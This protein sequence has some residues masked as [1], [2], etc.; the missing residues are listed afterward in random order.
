MSKSSFIWAVKKETP[1]SIGARAKAHKRVFVSVSTSHIEQD[2][3]PSPSVSGCSSQS[4]H[5]LSPGFASHGSL[6]GGAMARQPKADKNKPR[7][8][9]KDR[10]LAGLSGIACRKRT[11][12]RQIIT[13]NPSQKYLL[14][15]HLLLSPRLRVADFIKALF[16]RKKSCRQRKKRFYPLPALALLA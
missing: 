10:G 8:I 6:L 7:K 11:I 1:L 5:L 16:S 14:M 15:F 13:Y 3:D 4:R 9:P 12:D 2:R